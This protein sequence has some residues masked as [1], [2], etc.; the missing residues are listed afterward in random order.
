MLLLL[1]LVFAHPGTGGA[2]GADPRATI[3]HRLELTVGVDAVDLRYVA[4]VP[5]KRVLEEARAAGRPGYGTELLET[6]AAG[7]DLTWNGAELPAT[8]VVLDEPVAAGENRYLDFAVALHATL[9]EGAGTLGVRNGNYPEEPSFFATSVRL[10][11]GV[12]AEESSL[13]RVRDG[14]IR[15]NWHGAWVKDEKAREPWVRIRPA[16]LFEAAGETRPLPE[17]MAGVQGGLPVWLAVVLAVALV[18][19]ALLGRWL[20]RRASPAPPGRGCPRGG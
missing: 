16:G 15:D 19:L 3:G 8:R 12:V 20:G 14:R 17:A 7:V 18:P 1:P 10:G 13:L 6:L 2:G 4:E 11:A 9:P 5:E